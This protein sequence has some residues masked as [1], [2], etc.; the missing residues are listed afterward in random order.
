MPRFKTIAKM[1]IAEIERILAEK[2]AQ[3]VAVLR[4][5]RDRIDAELAKLT[6]G[7]PPVA[8]QK[9]RGRPPK[10]AQKP[11]RPAGGKP[12]RKRGRKAK[13]V[14]AK[15]IATLKQSARPMTA[16]ELA[17]AIAYTGSNLPATLAG[18]LKADK[19][20]R[21]GE[22]GSYTYSAAK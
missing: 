10:A 11:G 2:K 13:G 22:S 16:K 4:K 5:E 15:V 6:V 17:G 9:R 19:I 14:S 18:M 1:T 20:I 21:G 8:P 7:Q 12:G 3:A